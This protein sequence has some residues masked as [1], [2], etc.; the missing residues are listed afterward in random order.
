[1]IRFL[2]NE[3]ELGQFQGIAAMEIDGR[4]YTPEEVEARI[5]D[6]DRAEELIDALYTGADERSQS[7][8]DVTAK[9]EAYWG[10]VFASLPPLPEEERARVGRIAARALEKMREGR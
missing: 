4:R 10:E 2:L 6:L 7:H 3:G 9:I 1:M 5:A 8:T